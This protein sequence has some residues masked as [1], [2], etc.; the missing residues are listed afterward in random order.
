MISLVIF[1]VIFRRRDGEKKRISQ[2]FSGELHEMYIFELTSGFLLSDA[3]F[4]DLRGC[5]MQIYSALM[6]RVNSACFCSKPLYLVGLCV[7]FNGL[8]DVNQRKGERLSNRFRCCV[9]DFPSSGASQ[10]EVILFLYF[11][12]C[13][14]FLFKESKWRCYCT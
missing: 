13:N 1:G 4:G 3:A 11:C 8:S 10:V 2:M 5:R 7:S 12:L 9:V 6:R 14:F